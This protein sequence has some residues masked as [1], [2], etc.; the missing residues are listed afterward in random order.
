MEQG[1]RQVVW[2]AWRER[3]RQFVA[4]RVSASDVE[5]VLQEALLRIWRGLGDVRDE[6]RMNAWIYQVARSAIKDA[7]RRDGRRG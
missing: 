5:D 4:K 3:L 6:E 7:W 1:D 2:R